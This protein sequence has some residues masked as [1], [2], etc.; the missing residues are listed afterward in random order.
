[1]SGTSMAG[2]HVAG[3]AAIMK[4]KNKNL[5]PAQVKERIKDSGIDDINRSS[6]TPAER[7]DS[8]A[9]RLYITPNLVP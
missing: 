1:M 4:S 8:D 3:T 2:P 5:T 6:L 9:K 7:A